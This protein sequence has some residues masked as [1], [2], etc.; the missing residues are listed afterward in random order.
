MVDSSPGE[1]PS[2]ARGVVEGVRSRAERIETALLA[3]LK[4]ETDGEQPG[5]RHFR[6]VRLLGE[7]VLSRGLAEMQR[8]ALQKTPGT[9]GPYFDVNVLRVD[10]WTLDD[11]RGWAP[12]KDPRAELDY[13]TIAPCSHPRAVVMDDEAL[14]VMSRVLNKYLATEVSKLNAPLGEV[15]SL[16]TSVAAAREGMRLLVEGAELGKRERDPDQ[17]ERR[18]FRRL[19]VIGR[20]K[21]RRGVSEVE[22]EPIRRGSDLA[23]LLFEDVTLT[24]DGWTRSSDGRWTSP[25]E[26]PARARPATN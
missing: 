2:P 7:S 4:L 23:E 9:D 22:L 1:L 13:K 19:E 10:G 6:R 8:D 26:E 14:H 20:E 25:D 11:N 5:L 3:V 12:P 24:T 21:A 15:D 18:H 17:R 16:S